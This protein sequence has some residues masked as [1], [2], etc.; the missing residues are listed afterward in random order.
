MNLSSEKNPINYDL[1]MLGSKCAC[2]ESRMMEKVFDLGSMLDHP[3]IDLAIQK[4]ITIG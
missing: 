2:I 4:I 1:A 3:I